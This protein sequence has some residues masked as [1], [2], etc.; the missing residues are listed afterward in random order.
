MGPV[1]AALVKGLGDRGGCCSPLSA[2]AMREMQEGGGTF[3]VPQPSVVSGVWLQCLLSGGE[4][5]FLISACS[6]L[7]RS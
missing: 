1:N 5:C 3:V 4:Y 6:Y 2:R 7:E